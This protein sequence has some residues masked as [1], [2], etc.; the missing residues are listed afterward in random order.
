MKRTSPR[1]FRREVR[2]SFLAAIASADRACEEYRHAHDACYTQIVG[3]EAKVRS[4]GSRP[5]ETI[6]LNGYPPGHEDGSGRP[7]REARGN[8]ALRRQVERSHAAILAEIMRLE[9]RLEGE[10]RKL[11]KALGHLKPG[12]SSRNPRFELPIRGDTTLGAQEM[13]DTLEA[14]ARRRARGE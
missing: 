13:A 11:E 1:E 2:R 10:A 6:A 5:T 7:D 12:P 4:G 9:N 8:A 3:D 14:A